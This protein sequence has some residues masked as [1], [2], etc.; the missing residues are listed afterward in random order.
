MTGK[1][2]AYDAGV[3]GDDLVG[4]LDRGE[5]PFVWTPGQD[6]LQV[7][8]CNRIHTITHIYIHKRTHIHAHTHT[9]THT[10]THTHTRT[11]TLSLSHT[12]THAHTHT[13]DL[14]KLLGDVVPTYR[15]AHIPQKPLS[16]WQGSLKKEATNS[17]CIDAKET[18]VHCKFTQK[19]PTVWQGSV[20]K[21]EVFV[22]VCVGVC[23]CAKMI[24][25]SRQSLWKHYVVEACACDVCITK[26]CY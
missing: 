3:T 11:R 15:R 2:S 10:H 21:E 25:S 22:L 13:Q 14:G 20:E 12:H 4:A 18:N 23:T 19:P 1:A 26:M 7:H 8:T 9:R 5:R 6:K 17:Y 16:V 24:C